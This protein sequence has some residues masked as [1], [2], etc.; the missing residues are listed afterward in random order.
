M[1][2]V[3]KSIEKPTFKGAGGNIGGSGVKRKNETQDSNNNATNNKANAK[4]EINKKQKL[5]SAE[6]KSIAKHVS[7]AVPT[8]EVIDTQSNA[9]LEEQLKRMKELERKLAEQKERKLQI[10]QFLL[11]MRKSNLKEGVAGQTRGDNKDIKKNNGKIGDIKKKN[12]KG[13]EI[14]KQQKL[15]KTQRRRLK[16]KQRILQQQKEEISSKQNMEVGTSGSNQNKNIVENES[17]DKSVQQKNKKQLSEG[18]FRWIN[19]RLYTTTGTAAFQLFKE[20]PLMFEEYHKGFRSVVEAW[21]V[22]P[23]DIFID[24]LKQKPADIVVADLG[25]GEAKLAKVVPNKVLSFDLVASNNQVIACDIAK[26][27]VP[28]SL[29]DIAIF[30]L[31]GEL[32]IAEVVS[33]FTDI[34]A[35]I[36]LVREI[37]FEFTGKGPASKM[38]ITLDFRKNNATTDPGNIRWKSR[39]VTSVVLRHE[40]MYTGNLPYASDFEGEPEAFLQRIVKNLCLTAKAQDWGPGCMHWVKQLNGYLDLQYPLTRETRAVLAR[41]MFE[42]STASGIDPSRG[43]VYASI[44]MR[45]LKK[46]EKIGPEDLTLPWKPL[47]EIIDRTFFAKNRQKTLISDSFFPPETSE[48]IL[49]KILPIYNANSL[50]DAFVVQAYLVHFLPTRPSA[51]GQY[52]ATKWLSTIFSLW[53]LIPGSLI[54]QTEFLDLVARVAEDNVMIDLNDP[55]MIGVFTKDQARTVFATGSK[56]MDIPVGSSSAGNGRGTPIVGWA[57][58]VDMRAGSAMHLRKKADKFKM[59][60]KF[61]VFTMFPDDPSKESS[62]NHLANLIQAI[63]SYYHP[64]NFG[65]WT[66]S[67]VRFLQ[68]LGYEFLKRWKDE[69]NPECTTPLHRRLTTDIRHEFVLIIRNVTFLSMFGKDALSIGA[70]HAALKYLAWLE[71]TLIFPGLLERVY[72]SLETLTETHRTTS[73][74]SALSLLAIPLFSRVHYPAGGK[75]L[76]PLLNLVIPGIDMNDPIKTISSLI[77]ITHAIMGVPLID[78]TEGAGIENGFRWSGIEFDNLRDDEME[79]DEAE[80]DALC[81][82]STFEFVEWVEKFYERVFNIFKYLPKQENRKIKVHNMETGLVTVLLHACEVVGFQLSDK[83]HDLALKQVREF[84]SEHAIQNATKPMG[85]LCA[86]LTSPNRKKG[87][88]TFIP[89]CYDKIME[90]LEHDRASVPTASPSYF[91]QSDNTLHWY[92]CIL[93]HVVMFTGAEILVY[94]DKLIALGK[95]M[96]EKCLSRKGYIWAGKFIRM[97]LISLTQIYPTE[98]RS[99]DEERWNSDVYK[100]EHHKYWMEPGD[101]DNVKVNW[102]VP[103]DAELDFA[104]ELLQIFYE[105]AVEKVRQLKETS[106]GKNDIPEFCRHL[107]MIRNC[108][109]GTTTLVED[110]GDI[111]PS[112]FK[113]E[114]SESVH[115]NANNILPAGYCFTD[116]MDERRHYVR[117]LRKS[118]GELIH[119]L[120]TYFRTKR[121]DDL[122]SMKILLKMTKTYLTDRGVEKGKYEGSKRGYQYAKGMLK[123]SHGDKKYP[124]YLL[125]KRAYQQHLCRLKQNTFFRV[126]TRLHDDLFNDLVELSFSIYSEIRKIAQGYL[127]SASRCF[128]GAKPLII[129]KLLDGLLPKEEKKSE[130]KGKQPEEKGKQ[131][132]EKGK[133]PEEKGKQPE[134]AEKPEEKGK[135]PENKRKPG[136]RKPEKEQMAHPEIIKGA[137][138]LLNSRTLMHPCLKDWRFVPTFILR[139]CDAQHVDKPSVQELIR[140]V[141]YDYLTN[142]SNTMFKMISSDGLLNA[143]NDALTIHSIALDEIKYINLKTKIEK[144]MEFQKDQYYILLDDLLKLVKKE[145]LHWRFKDMAVKFLDVLVR[146]EAAPTADLVDFATKTLISEDAGLRKIAIST[147]TRILVHIKQRAFTPGDF[148]FISLNKEQNPLKR[149]IELPKPLPPNYTEQYL[150]TRLSPFDENKLENVFLHDKM[151]IG[152]Y[153]WPDKYDA[154]IPRPESFDFPKFEPTSEE[155]YK[156]FLEIFST[157]DFWEK[158]THFLSQESSRDREDN[159][160]VLNGHLFK[161]IFQMFEDQFLETVKP[162]IEKMCENPEEKHRQRAAAEILAGIVRGSKHWKL[163]RSK[164]MWDWLI[165]LLEKTFNAISLDSLTYWERFLSYCFRNHDPRRVYR[166]VDLVLQ[167]KIDHESNK[168]FDEAKKLFFVNTLISCYSWQ[169]IPKSQTLLQDYFANIRHP[170]KQVRDVL[171]ANLNILFQIQW[172]PSAPDVQT[173]LETNRNIP[174]GVGLIPTSLPKD[175]QGMVQELVEELAIWRAEKKPTAIGSSEYSNAGKTVLAWFYDSLSSWQATGT[176]SFIIPLLSEIFHM[177]DVND[178]Q[179]LQ[180]VAT[181]VL[182]MIAS[183]TYPPEMVLVMINKII[184]ILRESPSW[185]IKVKALPVLQ[186]FYFKH[187]FMLT[188]EEMLR[189]MN[190]VSDMLMDSQIEVRQMASETLSGLIRCSQRNAIAALKERFNELLKTK[191]PPRKRTDQAPRAARPP[192][193]Q[194]ALVS[195]HA[196]TLGLSCL[197]DA[198]P[199]EV[200]KWMPEVLVQLAK[201]I[202]DPVPIQTTVKKTFANFRRTH[203]DSWHEDKKEFTEDQLSLLSD[204]L[205]SPSYYA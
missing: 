20:D 143:I 82:A 154:Y 172:H 181:H 49:E 156:K 57:S 175:Y 34:D 98:C 67:I 145:E 76:A 30:C 79:V 6:S 141:Y 35:F 85:F 77:F 91:L 177:Q 164:A 72:P 126:R 152:W 61:I 153:A 203:Q 188:P 62:L 73:S 66:F 158:F 83:L 100:K 191:I 19:E 42:L 88:E 150:Q 127:A 160:S 75:H 65:R 92:Q 165:P 129:P 2:Q 95:M 69:Q 104:L 102:H 109:Q 16:K 63:E 180:S 52:L 166:L 80:E 41:I 68:F 51:D 105:P 12:E 130:E 128:I 179:D 40:R 147:T 7:F 5:N 25:C 202:S 124:R 4:N 9:S 123:T 60:A 162:L 108:L 26:L 121:E 33:R 136:R 189:I 139:I 187:L 135:Q 47:F 18:K 23:V 134:E 163:S 159:F 122:E 90:E 138:Y 176:Y 119:E 29:F 170:Y 37:G 46:K 1:K 56:M 113:D 74:I 131:P 149:T 71:P 133:Q 151:N 169:I 116:P 112:F 115:G 186:V 22:N 142:Y 89:L 59:M 39:I 78:L 167:S 148:D 10:D 32:K 185:H 84:A 103:T 171:A 24:F 44:C 17:D 55:N 97:L 99:V 117:D 87:L 36:E 192:E 161:S 101:K 110:D 173:L 13:G 197:I 120:I 28:D 168:S 106:S 53:Y 118:L 174:R 199:Y 15:S 58:R 195:R 137:L 200:P 54:Y 38:F 81:K 27:P 94:K 64:S 14:N 48:Q 194:N 193:F 96:V 8:F 144:R 3:N 140:K 50:G 111:E 93:Y 132:E 157:S 184:E 201:C 86:T 204:M 196:A 198:F 190:T 31:S 182:G 45:L 125:V 43:E 155:A 205:I 11:N 146:P 107:T 70:S 178:D 21:P 183:F 114:D